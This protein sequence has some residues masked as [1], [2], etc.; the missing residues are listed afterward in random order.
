MS[1]I[2]F[3]AKLNLLGRKRILKGIKVAVKGNQSMRAKAKQQLAILGLAFRLDELELSES[4]YAEIA[5]TAEVLAR[6]VR[7]LEP[8]PH[9]CAVYIH[10]MDWAPELGSWIHGH[11]NV[12]RPYWFPKLLIRDLRELQN[13]LD[14]LALLKLAKE[15][16]W[17]PDLRLRGGEN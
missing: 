12:E 13:D 17:G 11:N 14:D 9:G 3:E 1:L 15:A 6:H 8:M 4:V 2:S 7:Y 5:K 10:K 16:G